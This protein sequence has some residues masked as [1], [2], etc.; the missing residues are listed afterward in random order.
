MQALQQHVAQR[1]LVQVL[2]QDLWVGGTGTGEGFRGREVNNICTKVHDEGQVYH[3]EKAFRVP[4]SRA[5]F[6][7]CVRHRAKRGNQGAAG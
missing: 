6:R 7:I 5:L 4:S 1:V 2:V 3:R